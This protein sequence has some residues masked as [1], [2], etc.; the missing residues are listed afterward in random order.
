MP[1]APALQAVLDQMGRY[2]TPVTERP[3]RARSRPCVRGRPRSRRSATGPPEPMDAVDDRRRARAGRRAPVRVYRPSEPPAGTAPPVVV[4]LHGGGWVLMG[5][6]RRTTGICRRLAKASGAVVVSVDYRLAPEHP[7]P[8]ALD[9]SHAAAD[10]V[11]DPRLRLRRRRDAHRARGRQRGRQPAGGGHVAGPGDRWTAAS[12]AQVLVYPATDVVVRDRSYQRTAEGYLLEE[13]LDAHGLGAVPR[14]R[15]RSRRR[16]RVG[17]ARARPLGPAA[18]ARHHRR[19]R[20]AA[21]RGRGLRGTG[22]TVST[23]PPP[24]TATTA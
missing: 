15:R 9:D 8:A 1:V 7:F 13:A 12:S 4:Y 20:P 6:S 14:A 2:Q 10:W 24:C 5:D 17:A 21:R 23:C 11:V 18:G 3:G 19:V 16:V 22:S